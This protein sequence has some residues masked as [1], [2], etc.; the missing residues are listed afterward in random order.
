V[1]DVSADSVPMH[2]QAATITAHGYDPDDDQ[3]TWTWAATPYPPS[4]TSCP[5][6][7]D[8]ANW[9]VAL[10]QSSNA[11][12]PTSFQLSAAMTATSWC[13]WAMAT[14]R[15]GAMDADV[16]GVIPANNPPQPILRVV[17]PDPASSYAAYT[18]FVLGADQS[19]DLDGD[20]LTYKLTLTQAPS[21]SKAVLQP[22]PEPIPAADP[23][24]QCLDADVSGR[25]VV[26]LEISDATTTTTTSLTL[27]V[28]P[29]RLPCIDTTTPMYG[30]PSKD[31]PRS[32]RPVIVSMVDDDG[33]P[34][35]NLADPLQTV[36]FTW[37]KGK[38]DSGNLSYVD[39]GSF[40][41]LTLV[42]MDYQE[43]DVANIRL[44]IHDRNT[45]AI[46]AILLGCGNADFCPIAPG[47]PCNVRVSWRIVMDQ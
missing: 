27:N 10:G 12:A 17:T 18:H 19:S 21:A 6:K 15:Y 3:L 33:E 35:P 43:G 28:L 32:P 30:M 47:S 46:D 22:C 42:P 2:G 40:S 23:R 8:P 26:S 44:E 20:P 45:A 24:F 9:P 16:V 14:D 34:Y 25:Y 41:M 36:K 7:N 29:D 31:N 37:F 38:N 5:D 11:L 1:T 13:V 39:N 4:Q